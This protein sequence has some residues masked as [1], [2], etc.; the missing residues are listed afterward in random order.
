MGY[1]A[2][3]ANLQL[4]AGLVDAGPVQISGAGVNDLRVAGVDGVTSSDY[5]F[6]QSTRAFSP[7]VL[8]NLKS[9]SVPEPHSRLLATLACL[10]LARWSRNRGIGPADGCNGLRRMRWP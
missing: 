8:G 1:V 2:G 10:G 6:F 4:Y 5:F 9:V 3:V 7:D